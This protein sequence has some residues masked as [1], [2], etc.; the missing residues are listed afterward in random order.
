ML[1]TPK[2]NI[3]LFTRLSSRAFSHEVPVLVRD[4][5]QR[6]GSDEE[7]NPEA[8]PSHDPGGGETHTV[9]NITECAHSQGSCKVREGY[10]SWEAP[11]SCCKLISAQVQKFRRR[12][13]RKWALAKLP[14]V[15]GHVAHTMLN[16]H[17]RTLVKEEFLP[18]GL[19]IRTQRP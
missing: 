15:P 19:Q 5:E 7:V 17:P 16:V 4:R 2:Y 1:C 10:V 9:I 13:G 3:A 12:K 18:L 14:C 11:G 6:Q 8:S